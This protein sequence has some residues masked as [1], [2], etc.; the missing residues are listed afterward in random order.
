MKEVTGAVI[1]TSLVLIAVFVP[2]AFFPGTTGHPLPP[3]R[4]DHRLLHRHLRLQRPDPDARPSPRGCWAAR[5]GPRAGSSPAFDRVIGRV[6]GGLPRRAAADAGPRARLAMAVF[7]AGAG[8]ERRRLPRGA[9]R[10]RARRGPGLGH[11]PGAGAGGRLARVHAQGGRAGARRSCR[12]QPEMDTVFA[13]TGFSFAGTA[14]NRGPDVLRAQALL[15]A[16]RRGALGAG[17]DRAPA[18]RARASITEAMVFAFLPP[19]VE[20]LGTFG[21][22]QYVV[23][24]QGGHTLEEL[25]KVTQ[26]M[27]AAGQ[28]E[29][30]AR[31]PLHQL[32]RQRPA[33]RGDHRPRE[34][35]GRAACRSSRSRTRCRPTWAR[36]T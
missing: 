3:V 24:D 7:V 21:G 16:A 29:P 13:I 25:A 31:R 9:A 20:G 23:Q 18:R 2:V 22:F 19:P 11:D 14:P 12:R 5:T 10:L 27:V 6:D 34:G 4:A 28:R 35:Q 30:G 17:G 33:V 1:A 36:P 26:D 8:P 32:H 15:A